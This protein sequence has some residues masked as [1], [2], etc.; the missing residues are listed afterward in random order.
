M[1]PEWMRYI[2]AG[3][4]YVTKGYGPSQ[5]RALLVHI[6]GSRRIDAPMSEGG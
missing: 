6:L 2:L 1:R 4:H 3:R 5:S